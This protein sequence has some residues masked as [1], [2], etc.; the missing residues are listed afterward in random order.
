MAQKEVIRLIKKFLARL[1][2]EGI[3][4]KQTYLYGSY[5]S[6]K[7]GN[8]SDIDVMLISDFFDKNDDAQAGKVWRIGKN[9]DAR[10]EPYIVGMKR[11]KEDTISPLLRIIKKE[12]LKIQA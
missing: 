6:G 4:I 5:A 9:V 8:D 1:S 7:A 2:K 12:G 3:S 10:I 11:F